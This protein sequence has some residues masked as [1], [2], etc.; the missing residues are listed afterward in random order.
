MA[1]RFGA[2]AAAAPAERSG[3]PERKRARLR[4]SRPCRVLRCWRKDMAAVLI[5]GANRGIGLE[6]VRQYANDG[7]EVIA[8]ARQSSPEIDALGA[9]LELHDLSNAE[10][11][12]A[13][14]IKYQ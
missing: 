10:Y 6:F 1:R 9:R 12:C 4:L 8:T 14:A 7:W 11:D 5:T 3:K 2:I 13:F